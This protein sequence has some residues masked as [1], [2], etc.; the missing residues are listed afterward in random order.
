[1][2]QAREVLRFY[3]RFSKD[4]RDA[5]LTTPDGHDVAAIIASWFGAPADAARVLKPLQSFGLPWPT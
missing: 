1:M 2:N 5:L 4:A 3:A